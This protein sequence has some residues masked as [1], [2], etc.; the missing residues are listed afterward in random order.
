MRLRYPIDGDV[1]SVVRIERELDF[2]FRN[3]SEGY[4]LS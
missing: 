4:A 3:E 2:L 1:I